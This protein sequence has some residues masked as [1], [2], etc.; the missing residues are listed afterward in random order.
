MRKFAGLIRD[1]WYLSGPYFRS[2]ERWSAWGL[3]LLVLAADLLLVRISVLFNLNGGAWVNA[4]QS[5]DAASFFNLLFL[6]DA[7]DEGPFGIIP[8]FVPLVTLAVL[9]VVNGRYMRQWLQIRWRRWL[10]AR[11]QAEW[12]SKQAYY[13]LQLQPPTLGNDNP[14]QRISDDVRDFVETGLVLGF[15]FITNIFSMFSFLAILWQ[16]SFPVEIWGVTIP[17]YLVWVALFYAV[18]GT[19]LVHLVGKP[20]V[21]LNFVRQRLEA[22]YRFA[23]VRLR[24]NAEGVA[25]YGGER[26]EAQVLD[27]RFAAIFANFRRLMSRNRYL[28]AFTYSFTEIASIFP[29]FAA[30]PLYFAKKITFGNLSRVAGAFGEVQQSASWIVSNYAVLADWTA[31]VERLATFRR[32]LD[33]VHAAGGGNYV[34]SSSADPAVAVNDLRLALPDGSVLLDHGALRFERGESTAITGRSGGGKST[35]F[36]A[37][38]GIWPFGSGVVTRPPGSVL[39]LPQKPYIPLGTLRRAL[40]YPAAEDAYANE[41]VLAAL[42]DAGLGHL[43]AELDLDAMWAQRLSGGEQQR[44]ALARALLA[45]P[46]WLFLDEATAS[47]D[48]EGQVDLYRILKARLPGTGIVSIVHAPAVVALHDRHLVLRRGPE[49]GV[50]A[51][52]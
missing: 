1:I 13:R 43:A 52:E 50:L 11:Y 19:W 47:L 31:T 49:G 21:S 45:R 7:S 4:L 44:L 15:G 14:D 32:S 23:L 20:L 10:T 37:L 28:N 3:L 29:W 51:A 40:S 27:G 16:L 46:D 38:A 48:P 5:Y 33:A 18:I 9:I 22:D 34:A 41:T 25:L 2:E 26:D 24:E 17:A 8:G 35:L 30:T 36:R 6:W 42:A 39:F 12:L